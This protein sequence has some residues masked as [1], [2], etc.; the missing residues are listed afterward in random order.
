VVSSSKAFPLDGVQT[1]AVRR[2]RRARRL[3]AP[4][5]GLSLL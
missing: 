1:E 2:K 3:L 4:V 5:Q